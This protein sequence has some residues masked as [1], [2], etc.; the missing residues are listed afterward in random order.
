MK[1]LTMLGDLNISGSNSTVPQYFPLILQ[2]PRKL[3]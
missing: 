2:L 1:Q 3:T